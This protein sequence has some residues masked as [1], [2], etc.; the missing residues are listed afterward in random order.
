MTHEAERNPAPELLVR[1]EGALGRL[2][3]NRPEALGA[4]TLGMCE[5]MT[6]ALLEWRDDPAVERVAVDHAGRGFCAGGDI[7]FLADSAAQGGEG[8]FRFFHTEYRLDHLMEVYP[9]P[10]VALMDGVTMGGGVGLSLPARYRVATERTRFAMPETGIGLF[11]DVGGGWHLP[12]LPGRVGLW[13]VLTGARLGPADCRR[14]GVANHYV[15]SA[16]LDLLKA[17]LAKPGA[18]ID[19]AL[20]EVAGDAGSAPIEDQ[21]GAIDAFFAEESVEAIVTALEADGT[22]WAKTQLAA[23]APKCP[24]SAK[25]SFRQIAQLRPRTF[26]DDMVIEYRLARRIVM[27]PDFTEGVRAVIVEKDNAPVWSP[28]TS[29]GV[30]EALVDEMFAP[31]PAGEEWTPLPA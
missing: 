12:R 6:A 4:L 22:G 18:D 13:M 2:T 17:A 29:E 26:A 27:R 28:S 7:R 15:G 9:K 30:T 24:L 20:A 10:I 1:R 11:P 16:N 23:M 21:I 25:V 14:I 5:A 8:A 3:L 31:L 19:A